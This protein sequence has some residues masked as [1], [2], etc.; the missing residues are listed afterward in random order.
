[1]IRI[2]PLSESITVTTANTVNNGAYIVCTTTAQTLITVA[3]AN[4][5]VK[6]SF[7]SPAN[8]VVTIIKGNTDTIAA[9]VAIFCTVG[10][11]S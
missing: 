8:Y 1:M 9:N 7:T 4:G 5:S 2:K 11:A 6:G 3:Y 10:A